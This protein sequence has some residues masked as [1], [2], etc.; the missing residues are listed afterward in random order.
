MTPWP[1]EIDPLVALHA[2]DPAPFEEFVRAGTRRLVAFFCHRGASL[3]RAE[4]LTQEV[5]LRMYQGAGRYRPQERFSAYCYR[6]ARNLWIDECRRAAPAADGAFAR[7]EL[8]TPLEAVSIAHDP[9]SDL[10]RAEE[11]GGLQALLGALPAGQRRVLEL[12]LLFELTY[13]EIGAQLSIPVGT[14]KSRM[15]HAVRR[16]RSAW[17]ERRQRE[18]VA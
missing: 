12:A 13:A 9:A 3:G 2:G 1:H 14:V 8:R 7:A 15:F 11:E 17:E 18:G 10:L 5:F 16:L 6:A 4:E